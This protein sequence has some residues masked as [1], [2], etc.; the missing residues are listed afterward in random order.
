LRNRS[1]SR[2]S[3]HRFIAAGHY[4][5]F[6]TGELTDVNVVG[7]GEA[8]HACT[9]D[10]RILMSPRLALFAAGMIGLAILAACGGGGEGSGVAG[11]MV[12]GVISGTATKGPIAN[13]TVT[14]YGVNG[15]HVG[16]RIG[17]AT[18]DAS[19]NFTLTVGNHGGAVMLQVSGG[20]YIDEATGTSMVMAAGDLMTAAIPAV[21]AGA[22]I[23]NV[24]VTPVTAMAQAMAEHMA[25]GMSDANIAAANAAM[26]N[27][28]AVADIL[29]THPMNPTVV[30]SAGG[31]DHDARNYGITL[32][33]MCQYAKALN[34]AN[35]S[36]MMTAMMNDAADGV[37]DGKA[38]ASH[39]SMHMGGM[40]GERA[41]GSAAGTSDLSAAM[42]A[43]MNS[44]ANKS[45]MTAADMAALIQK[46]GSGNGH[47]DMD[48]RP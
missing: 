15:G 1:G 41:M 14:A 34:M 47:I 27:Y 17:A 42:T 22:T 3:G 20:S 7:H 29:H 46:L 13:A 23:N 39:V 26:G 24:Q 12:T 30:A 19:G 48:R 4:E 21:V 9:S 36:A 16:D 33:A 5:L 32:A 11:D 35:S 10:R 8:Q 38:G 40:M 18:T 6:I 31:A 25:G 43:F 28:F 45:G 37:M 44:P 2:R